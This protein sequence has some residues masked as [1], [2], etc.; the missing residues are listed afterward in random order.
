MKSILNPGLATGVQHALIAV[1]CYYLGYRLVTNVEIASVILIVGG[2]LYIADSAGR[3]L[4]RW[5]GEPS[6][7]FIPFFPQ[8][9]FEPSLL[10]GLVL[11]AGMVMGAISPDF[12]LWA[13]VGD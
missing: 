10:L 7:G 11:C 1:A 12:I 4:T 9:E 3:Y 8:D 2:L 6:G 5:V 13:I